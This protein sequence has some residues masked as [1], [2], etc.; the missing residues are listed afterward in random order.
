MNA[1]AYICFKENY[2]VIAIN[3]RKQQE[4]D[5]DPKAMQQTNFTWNLEQDGNTQMFFIDEET[6]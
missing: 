1:I 4:L 3:L 5:A 2:K 6:K